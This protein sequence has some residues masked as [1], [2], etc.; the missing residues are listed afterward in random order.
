M[1]EQDINGS[2]Q[3]TPE[4]LVSV[5]EAA[6]AVGLTDGAVHSWIKRGRLTAYVQP[7]RLGRQGSV[8]AVRALS[9]PLDSQAP[10]EALLVYA[11]ARALGVSRDRITG[12]ARRGVLPSWQ[13]RHGLLV[14]IVDAR[15]VA[16]RQGLLPSGDEGG[17]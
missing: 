14:R 2:P 1:E 10:P 16:Q 15:A 6:R 7:G 8:R 3:Q 9:A 4:D 5:R 13:G 12:W 17:A 11:V